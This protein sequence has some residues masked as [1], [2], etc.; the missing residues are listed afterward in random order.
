[1]N[2]EQARFNMVEQQI[3]PWSVLDGTVLQIMG[4]VPRDAF[5]VDDVK[6]MAYAD[7]EI[8]LEHGESMMFPRVEGRLLQELEIDID[9]ECLEI[10]TGS[11]F[12]TACMATMAKHVHSIDIHDDFLQSASERLAENNIA[13]VLLESKDIFEPTLKI[14]KKYDAIAVTGS[15]PEYIPL[16][17]QLLKPQGRL[18]IVVG[19]G[20]TMHAMKV[21]R[22]EGEN[23]NTFARTSLFETALKPLVGVE[24]KS[25]F[26][27]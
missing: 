10:G 14:T 1:M 7:I 23:H 18:F 21:I 15:I 12:V 13:N 4:S 19:S 2:Y 6:S 9:D 8:P 3:R 26:S 5:V 17:E 25:S 22:G 20:Q 11:G 16:F 27:F 24:T